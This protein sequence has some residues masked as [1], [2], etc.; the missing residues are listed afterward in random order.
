MRQNAIRL[1]LTTMKASDSQNAAN[2]SIG[3]LH[4]RQLAAPI[5]FALAKQISTHNF[6][7]QKNNLAVRNFKQDFACILSLS[8]AQISQRKFN[9]LVLP[10]MMPGKRA[11]CVKSTTAE[12]TNVTYLVLRRA[13]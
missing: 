8:M 6:C 11:R 3:V 5:I 9:V 2:N 13:M 4:G 7:F 10:C 1:K 12:K